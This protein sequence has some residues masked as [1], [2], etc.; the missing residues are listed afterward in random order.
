ML[1]EATTAN[2]RPMTL[3]QLRTLNRALLCAL[4]V[5]Y[6]GLSTSDK[7]GADVPKKPDL[8]EVIVIAGGIASILLLI[9]LALMAFQQ[10]P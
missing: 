2:V 1:R 3:G 9:G 10:H 5:L 6:A 7:P 8:F 4:V